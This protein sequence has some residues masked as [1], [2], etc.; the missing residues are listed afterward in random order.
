[1]ARVWRAL[2]VIGLVITMLTAAAGAY[3]WSGRLH[4]ESE[5]DSALTFTGQPM[6]AD[7]DWWSADLGWLAL[8]DPVTHRTS[9]V[10]TEDGGHAWERLLTVSGAVDVRFFD[11]WHGIVVVTSP[12]VAT[13]R[14][15]LE[16]TDGGWH[17][18]QI[19]LPADAGLLPTSV[20]FMG[21]GQGWAL[22]CD[23]PRLARQP[24]AL[25]GTEDAGRHW[26]E[27]LRTGDQRAQSGITETG[28]KGQVWFRGPADGWIWSTEPDGS[29]AVYVTR[30]GGR[31]WRKVALPPPPGGWAHFDAQSGVSNISA[32]GRG[33]LTV[34]GAALGSSAEAPTWIYVTSDAGETWQS[35]V[36][37]SP[38]A[39]FVDGPVGWAGQQGTAFVTW[40]GGRLWISRG[41]LPLGWVFAR[42][43][44]A[45]MTEAAAQAVPASS[46]GGSSAQLPWR[47]FTTSDRGASWH[48][49][50][51]PRPS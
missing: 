44:P 27:L 24:C 15:V 22:T 13:V 46:L 14:E 43:Q 30:D 36:L 10:R 33:T 31:Q 48:E 12:A 23:P 19:I 18:D 47:L 38:P 50:V 28:I 40:D 4:L 26:S 1:M 7:M 3:L 5:R 29:G 41:R 17:W 16:T 6:L 21:A 9:L 20:F 37:P 39:W 45:S 42:I 2:A 49:A 8:A 25:Y 35:P 32:D 51:V 11:R 34:T